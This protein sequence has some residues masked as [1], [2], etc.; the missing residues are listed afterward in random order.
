MFIFQPIGIP[1]E[2]EDLSM[3]QKTIEHCRG[4][5]LVSEHL[6]PIGEALVGGNDDRGFLVE[7]ANEV[8]ERVRFLPLDRCVTDVR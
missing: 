4:H 1:I 5:D 3:V 6:R 8:E 2:V 7:L